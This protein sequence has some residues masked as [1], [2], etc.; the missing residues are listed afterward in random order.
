MK[1]TLFV[2][3]LSLVFTTTHVFAQQPERPVTAKFLIEGCIEYG[4]DEILKVLFT[5]G[6]DQTMRAGQGGYN[7]DWRRTTI[8]K[9]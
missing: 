8:F 5:N 7:F 9:Y 1:K 2:L 6:E 3:Y 4:G